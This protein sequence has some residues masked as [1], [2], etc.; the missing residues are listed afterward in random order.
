M[1]GI[2][3]GQVPSVAKTTPGDEE[4]PRWVVVAIVS[5]LEAE[6]MRGKLESEGIPC[7]LQREAAGSVFGITI[8][9]LGEVRVLVPEPLADR[10]YDLLNENEVDD[11]NEVTDDDDLSADEQL[12]NED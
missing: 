9:P 3:K 7:L 12:G 2:L 1:E 10:A 4:S 11:E 8:G 5:F 6:V